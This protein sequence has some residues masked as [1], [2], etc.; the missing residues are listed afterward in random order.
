MPKISGWGIFFY[1]KGPTGK[2]YCIEFNNSHYLSKTQCHNRKIFATDP[3]GG[4]SDN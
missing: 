4:Q 1:A 2:A 3:E